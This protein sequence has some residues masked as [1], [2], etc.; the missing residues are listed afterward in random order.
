MKLSL[1]AAAAVA[2]L[3][4]GSRTAS[5]QYLVP[6]RGHY[7]V[8][9]SYSPPVYG[10]YGYPTYSPGVVVGSYTSPGVIY[11]GYSLYPTYGPTYGYGGYSGYGTWGGHHHH[12]HHGR[13]W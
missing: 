9:P 10:G 6:H 11:G 3:A 7:H 8:A 4:L 12:H 13:H 2:A 1:I 5:A